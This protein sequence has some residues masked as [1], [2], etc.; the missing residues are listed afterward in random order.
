MSDIVWSFTKANI[1]I[2]GRH[3]VIEKEIL[4]NKF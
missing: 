4:D 1:S 3:A 2:V